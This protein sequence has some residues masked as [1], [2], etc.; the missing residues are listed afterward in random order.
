MTAPR[1]A[2]VFVASFVLFFVFVPSADLGFG[3]LEPSS[4]LRDELA[5]GV[6]LPTVEE[7]LSSSRGRFVKQDLLP[8]PCRDDSPASRSEPILDVPGCA[9]P[10]L[11]SGSLILGEPFLKPQEPSRSPAV[12][13]GPPSLS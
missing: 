8:D 9:A 2:T 13:R 6:L 7:G 3:E 12:P 4:P 1:L 11:D 10:L 5:A